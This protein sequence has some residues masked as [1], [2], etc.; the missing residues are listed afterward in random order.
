GCISGTAQPPGQGTARAELMGSTTA[1]PPADQFRERVAALRSLGG[2]DWLCL[3]NRM[4]RLQPAAQAPPSHPEKASSH[5]ADKGES[6][7]V[8]WSEVALPDWLLRVGLQ[9]PSF[10]DQL[11][12]QAK[13]HA[14]EW[15]MWCVCI[16]AQAT[17]VVCTVANGAGLSLLELECVLG[18]GGAVVP[19]FGRCTTIAPC[20]M[21]HLLR[22]P[23][24]CYLELRMGSAPNSTFLLL[25]AS[26][27]D[28]DDLV[29]R[30]AATFGLECQDK[31]TPQHV[32]CVAA[33]TLSA[34]RFCGRVLLNDVGVGIVHYALV[35]R[36]EIVI[37]VENVFSA[38]RPFEVK[39]TWDVA[40][41]VVDVQ[42]PEHWPSAVDSVDE[43][44]KCGFGVAI[45][46]EGGEKFVAR[47]QARDSRSQ[48]LE[49]FLAARNS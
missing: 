30:F 42:L 32:E 34:V 16:E 13:G 22:G 23:H 46:F 1:E 37:V 7:A 25:P 2:N 43:F 28:T 3:L 29:R 21:V 44:K 6:P 12:A 9:Q 49:A 26:V 4:H 11:Q 36:K 40:L 38:L 14:P 35:A 24:R 18:A 17:S 27:E 10:Q 48:F 31:F 47:F 45:S 20:E 5:C 8:G 39:R 15:V 41:P 19:Q 33:G